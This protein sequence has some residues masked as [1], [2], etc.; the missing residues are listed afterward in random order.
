[1]SSVRVNKEQGCRL[2]EEALCDGRSSNTRPTPKYQLCSAFVY[3]SATLVPL[4][5]RT[6]H[7]TV[8]QAMLRDLLRCLFSNS[9]SSSSRSNNNIARSFHLLIFIAADIMRP[10]LYSCEPCL[11]KAMDWYP[12]KREPKEIPE[13]CIDEEDFDREEFYCGNC[14][15][16][17]DCDGGTQR[18][19]SL[20][21]RFIQHIK[22]NR[23]LTKKAYDSKPKTIRLRKKASQAIASY[24]HRS[25]ADSMKNHRAEHKRAIA[26]NTLS[27]LIDINNSRRV[28]AQCTL[29]TSGFRSG[30]TDAPQMPA[31]CGPDKM[32]EECLWDFPLDEDEDEEN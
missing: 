12:S 5:H 27:C 21:K 11:K 13:I 19:G 6:G 2:R 10:G 9:D 22:I 4:E 30:I 25:A 14:G 18:M 16:G 15:G 26:T 1:M 31:R 3:P 7:A 23:R 32:P 8:P 24:S 20:L 28:I 29:H 17:E